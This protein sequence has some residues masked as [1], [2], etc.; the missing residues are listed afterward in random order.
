M[1][2]FLFYKLYRMAV[3][4][5]DSVYL[6]VGFL[7]YVTIFEILHL[8]ILSV[9][10]DIFGYK[11]HVSDSK[12]VI[13]S[14]III[15]GVLNYFVFIKTKWIYRINEYYQ[16]KKLNAWK[17]NL[18]FVGYIILLFVIMFIQTWYYQKYKV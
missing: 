8:A 7:V 11:I 15:I 6:T 2:R 12:Y 18:L 17:S 16:A 14:Y 5:Q 4:E 9:L 13:Y 1:Y 3:N 10:I